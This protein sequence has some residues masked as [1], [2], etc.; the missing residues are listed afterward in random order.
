VVHYLSLE[1]VSASTGCH[2]ILTRLGAELMA[3]LVCMSTACGLLTSQLQLRKR[4]GFAWHMLL[5]GRQ[6]GGVLL[7]PVGVIAA[8]VVVLKLHITHLSG[9]TVCACLLLCWIAAKNTLNVAYLWYTN[10]ICIRL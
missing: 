2:S 6:Y 9:E 1:A 4:A 8:C 10:L 5:R 3:Q 7:P